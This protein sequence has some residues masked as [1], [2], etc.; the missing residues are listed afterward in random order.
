[1]LT[2]HALRASDFLGTLGANGGVITE[3]EA[4]SEIPEFQYAGIT[5]NRMSAGSGGTPVAPGVYAAFCEAG[6]HIDLLAN[7]GFWVNGG[8]QAVANNSL[9]YLQAVNSL[10]PGCIN[11][12]EGMNE[13][14]TNTTLG[15]TYAQRVAVADASS[16][17]I[18][19]TIKPLYPSV[20][21]ALWAPGGSWN[22]SENRSNQPNMTAFADYCTMHD[23]YGSARNSGDTFFGGDNPGS[24]SSFSSCQRNVV[25]GKQ[26]VATEFGWSTSE[27]SPI[28]AGEVNLDSQAKMDM[29]KFLDHA[30]LG[31]PHSYVFS[32]QAAPYGIFDNTGA[33]FE[34]A[35]ALHNLTSLLRDNGPNAK[36]F[37]STTFQINPSSV[38][39]GLATLS[40]GGLP[41]GHFLLVQK[42]NGSLWLLLWNEANVWNSTNMAENVINPATVTINLPG[43]VSGSIYDPFGCAE[44]QSN[45]NPLAGMSPVSTFAEATKIPLELTDHL[46]IVE[47]SSKYPE[48][49]RLSVGSSPWR[50]PS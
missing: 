32:M 50:S 49:K 48:T 1:M 43:P 40:S 31:M 14:D 5:N 39:S 27:N 23:Y 18:W 34:A 12:V 11:M 36:T 46:I 22:Y 45:C 30:Q 35:I 20:P 17:A 41:T 19:H 24:L 15:S 47:L 4:T 33:P 38:L 28:S 26:A 25:T 16:V 42:S 44:T 37:A 9:S 21:I 8:V 6:I 7:W 2:V 13:P 10:V 29:S 3:A